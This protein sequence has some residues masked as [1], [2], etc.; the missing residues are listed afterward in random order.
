MQSTLEIG[1]EL[2]YQGRRVHVKELHLAA[3]V[4]EDDQGNEIVV[5]YSD[6]DLIDPVDSVC[7][8][9]NPRKL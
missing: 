2:R 5:N 7:R 1:Q 4:V 9:L 3:V 8:K 6:P